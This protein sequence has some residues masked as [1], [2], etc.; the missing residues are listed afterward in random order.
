MI[1]TDLLPTVQANA[2]PR[3][4]IRHARMLTK[5]IGAAAALPE[6]TGKEARNAYEALRS[7]IVDAELGK[8]PIGELTGF[9][10]RRSRLDILERA[11]YRS[12]GAVL[13]AGPSQLQSIDGIGPKTATQVVAEARRTLQ[14]LTKQ[15][16]VRFDPDNQTAAQAT[17]LARLHAH[18][19]AT[20]LAPSSG[21]DLQRLAAS[22]DALLSPAIPAASRLRMFFSGSKRKR[23]ARSALAELAAIM[24]QPSTV[25][26]ITRLTDAAAYRPP[27]E[28]ALWDDY[29]ARSAAYDSL[30]IEVVGLATPQENPRPAQPVTEGS[31]SPAPTM[32]AHTAP[33]RQWRQQPP[34][35]TW[36]IPSE[37]F[38]RQPVKDA[39]WARRQGLQDRAAGDACWTYSA[40]LTKFQLPRE[41]SSL[42]LWSAYTPSGEQYLPA[43]SKPRAPSQ[44]VPAAGAPVRTGPPLSAQRERELRNQGA[45]AES[46]PDCVV[47]FRVAG[48]IVEQ[49]RIPGGQRK[50]VSYADAFNSSVKQL[51]VNP[52]DTLPDTWR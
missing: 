37:P 8:L 44:P 27:D 51:H 12:V 4:L 43:S 33:A 38:P 47:T 45:K 39:D 49:V 30:L 19:R 32:P 36:P 28:R 41:P 9:A 11:G 29:L 40:F 23:E 15:T 3:D 50:A 24:R 52:A 21:S 2:T 34:T 46:R 18:E 16:M 35:R 26:A 42:R 7:G 5:A 14:A 20:E 1:A 25:A 17:L 13:R 48:R 6:Q 10:Q 22:I 31:T